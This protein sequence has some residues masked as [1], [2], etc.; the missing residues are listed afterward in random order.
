MQNYNQ[1]QLCKDIEEFDRLTTKIT[2]ATKYLKV[3]LKKNNSKQ[4]RN[5]IIINSMRKNKIK[6]KIKLYSN[7]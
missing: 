7:E 1:F 4:I 6:N 2:N 3:F 5:V